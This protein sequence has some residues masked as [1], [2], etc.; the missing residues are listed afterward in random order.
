MRVAQQAVAGYVTHAPA[1]IAQYNA[2]P[3]D[4]IYAGVRDLLPDTPVKVLDVG[5]GSGRDA[6]WCASLG[7]TVTA[8][9]PV[10]AFVAETMR[11]V[12]AATI[13]R[14]RL[15]TLAS[16]RGHY[17]LILVN[18]VWQHVDPQDRA[19][20]L[21]RLSGLL[22]LGGRLILSLRH[23]P[24]HPDRPIVPI[25]TGATLAQGEALGLKMLRRVETGSLQAGNTANG[26]TWTWLVFERD[27]EA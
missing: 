5:T 11:R 26:V 24:G 15:P 3:S 16:V 25:D 14:D 1:L 8:V 12:P 9:D 22:D 20:A 6:E 17:G 4:T 23:G 18:G 27:G 19:A 2:V 10:A 21:R 13:L 7:H